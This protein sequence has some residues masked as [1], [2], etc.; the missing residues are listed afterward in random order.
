M[1]VDDEI[2]STSENPVQNKV[3]KQE[4]DNIMDA[5]GH[6]EDFPTDEAGLEIYKAEAENTMW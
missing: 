2:S 6:I 3:I 1:V 5:I 4:I